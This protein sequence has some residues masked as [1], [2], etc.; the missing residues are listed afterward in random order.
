MATSALFKDDN[1]RSSL[2]SA[3]KLISTF[4]SEQGLRDPWQKRRLRR[5]SRWAR[6]KRELRRYLP[7]HLFKPRATA[8]DPDCDDGVG[9]SS[10]G[11]QVP[12]GLPGKTPVGPTASPPDRGACLTIGAS[13][14]MERADRPGMMHQSWEN[15]SGPNPDDAANGPQ[16]SEVHPYPCARR[17]HAAVS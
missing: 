17:P 12:L 16:Y 6:T 13:L 9:G 3:D 2:S 10:I 14:R 8:D 15:N 4:L 1:L 11:S 7:R 5:R